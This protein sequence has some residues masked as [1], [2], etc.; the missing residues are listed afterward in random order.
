MYPALSSDQTDTL[1]ETPPVSMRLLMAP[2]YEW[3][4]K[5]PKI[6]WMMSVNTHMD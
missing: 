6:K 2:E 3:V 4:E 5:N 1:V